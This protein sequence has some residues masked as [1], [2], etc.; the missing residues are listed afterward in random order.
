VLPGWLREALRLRSEARD[1]RRLATA[2]TDPQTVVALEGLADESD[3]LA[4]RLEVMERNR[5][6]E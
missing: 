1:C 2:F 5:I 4:D 3:E 6:S